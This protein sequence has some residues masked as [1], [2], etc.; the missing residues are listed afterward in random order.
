VSNRNRALE[1]E[2][3]WEGEASREPEE[4]ALL[5]EQREDFRKLLEAEIAVRAVGLEPTTNGL[6]VRCSTD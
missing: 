1:Q 3:Q 4:F 2:T 5:T 6:K